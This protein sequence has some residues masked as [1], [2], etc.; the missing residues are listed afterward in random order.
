MK[1]F[2]II[3]GVN[4]VGKSSLTGVLKALRND[5]GIIIECETCE[6]AKALSADCLEKGIDFTEETTLSG[7]KT[8][9]TIIAAKEK[10]YYIRLYYVAVSS[11]EESVRRIEN[12]VSKGGHNIPEEDVKRRFSHR[13]DDFLTILPYCSE[14]HFYDNENGFEEVGEYGNGTLTVTAEIPPKWLCDLKGMI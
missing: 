1:I 9:K 2:T 12:R 4:G 14:V 11:A 3:G 10:D 8:L 13:Y 6:N 7:K 5:M